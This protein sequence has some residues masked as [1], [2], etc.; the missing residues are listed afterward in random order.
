[1]RLFGGKNGESIMAGDVG[2]ILLRQ[3]DREDG[4]KG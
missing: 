4:R 2:K 1:M 3:S